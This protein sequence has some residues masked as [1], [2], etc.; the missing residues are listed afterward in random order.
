MHF[1]MLT[2]SN[3]A[4]LAA[5][6]QAGDEACF[7]VLY[8]RHAPQLYRVVVRVLGGDATEADDV[9]QETWL[10]ALAALGG[11]RWESAF[12]RWLIGIGIN[13]A[14]DALRRRSR[15]I[16]AGS[17]GTRT[18]RLR[19]RVAPI[20]ERIDLE[21]AVALLPARRRTVLV[22]HDIE[23]YAHEEIGQMLGCHVG[24]SKSQL[25]KARAKLREILA[26]GGSVV[27]GP[28]GAG[29]SSLLNAV[30]P[31]LQL[32]TG[33]LSAKVG[34]GRH[35]TVSAVMLPLDGGGFLVDTPGFSEVGLWGVDPGE[36]DDCFPEFRPWLAQCRYADCVHRS[37]PGCRVRE[38]LERG[39]ID[40]SRYESYATLFDE[41]KSAPEAWE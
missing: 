12:S 6:V 40:P 28:S 29:K 3:D 5:G 10:R 30:Q 17:D 39:E 2:D 16:T 27:T 14:R 19:A 7:H 32:R 8:A 31:G 23:G 22:L 25:H 37:E 38:A 41:L 15:S 21:R 35:T 18:E 20:G 33:E 36:L 1:P 9:V 26:A 34:R 11:F 24:T 13:Q 4:E